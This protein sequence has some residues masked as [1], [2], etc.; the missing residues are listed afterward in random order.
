M[1]HPPRRRH[2][3]YG[4]DVAKESGHPGPLRAL[5]RRDGATL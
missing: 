5:G 4:I 2:T 3:I 1:I